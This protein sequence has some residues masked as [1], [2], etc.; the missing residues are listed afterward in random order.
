M[1]HQLDILSTIHQHLPAQF[2][3]DD[4]I[5]NAPYALIVQGHLMAKSLDVMIYMMVCYDLCH[6]PEVMVRTCDYN[7]HFSFPATAL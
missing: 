1:L 5:S 7:S 6:G 2:T 4:Y 3:K